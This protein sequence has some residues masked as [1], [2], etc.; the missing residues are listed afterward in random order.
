MSTLICSI[1]GARGRHLSVYDNK[2][3]VTTNVTLGSLLTSNA[4]DGE[5]TIFYI[6][7]QGVQ[8]KTCGLALGYLQLETSSV[9][10]NN[11]NSNMFSENTFTFEDNNYL[12]EK[13][14][15]YIVDR[16]ESYKYNTPAQQKYLYELISAAELTPDCQIASSLVAQVKN[17][18]Q[19][20]EEHRRQEKI[21]LEHEAN[22]KASEKLQQSLQEKD[23]SASLKTFLSQASTCSRIADIYKLWQNSTLDDDDATA[24]IEQKI[25]D[26]AQ[27][28][29]MYGN[30]P[31]R[32]QNLLTEIN[33][34]IS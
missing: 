11:L 21:R 30:N 19:D 26:A 1:P 3:V 24:L 6:D 2:C 31:N 15:I 29:R 27:I 28:E 5:K 18:Q 33:N 10:M 23:F 4:L 7:V 17:E 16:I 8:F 32:V 25:I 22:Q 34:L 9:Q 12:M 13:V 14:H 20:Q